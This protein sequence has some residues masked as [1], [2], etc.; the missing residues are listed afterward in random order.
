MSQ[1]IVLPLR[2]LVVLLAGLALLAVAALVVRTARWVLRLSRRANGDEGAQPAL[3][4]PDS[5]LFKLTRHQ[6]LVDRLLLDAL[7]SS[8]FGRFE[9]YAGGKRD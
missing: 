3:P 2:W 6:A 9:T 7:G 8:I 1:G 5:P 4:D